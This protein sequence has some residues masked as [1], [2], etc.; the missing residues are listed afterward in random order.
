MT[1]RAPIAK[2][3]IGLAGLALLGLRFA[4]V[5]RADTGTVAVD[6]VAFEIGFSKYSAKHLDLTGSNLS[7]PEFKD[8]LASL[9]KGAPVDAL[10][11]LNAASVIIP[12]LTAEQTFAGTHQIAHYLD[13][14]LTDIHDGKVGSYSIAKGVM[15]GEMVNGQTNTGTMHKMGG[16]DIDLAALAR[17]FSTSSADASAPLKPLYGTMFSDG[18]EMTMPMVDVSMGKSTMAGISGRPLATSL[19]DIFKKLPQPKTPGQ[20]MSPE[21]QRAALAFMPDFLEIYSAFAMRE[22]DMHDLRFTFRGDPQH[23]IPPVTTYISRI[24][25]NDYGNS[26][27]GEFKILGVE[28]AAPNGKFHLGSFSLKGFE[29]REALAG[30][31]QFMRKM[32]ANPAGEPPNP[33]DLKVMKMPKLEALSLA[34]MSADFSL[35]GQPDSPVK[36]MQFSVA[37]FE[38]K[39]E[40]WADGLPRSVYSKLDHCVFNLVPGNSTSDPLIAAGFAKLD[41]SSTTDAQWDETTQRLT[42]ATARAEGKDLGSATIALTADNLAHEAFNGDQFTRQAAW[43]GALLKSLDV[44][45]DNQKFL[46]I[47]FAA[48]A[49]KAGKSLDQY[50]SE[51]IAGAAVTIPAVL[52]NSPAAKALASAVTRFLADPKSLHVTITS[53]DGIGA[54][55]AADPAHILD[56]VDLTATANQ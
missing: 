13:V 11:K 15:A 5:A 6:D 47:G 23:P 49:K 45:L 52:G 38:L 7:G 3:A 16:T 10:A 54:G 9:A 26:H 34:D 44:K 8:L 39:P 22:A 41:L 53:K 14:K 2:F 27:I 50:R 32:A 43:L 28:V 18:F 30:L 21:D 1:A 20:P 12:D 56:K 46:D 33:E 51:L 48:E 25:L 17:V 19:A 55:D 36:P 24:V 40:L 31:T 35:P 4:T 29:F 42:I 37:S